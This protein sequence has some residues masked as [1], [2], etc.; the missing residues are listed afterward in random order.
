MKLSRRVTL[1]AGLGLI[2]LIIIAQLSLNIFLKQ[3]SIADSLH[4]WA[5]ITL[6]KSHQFEG[7]YTFS[8]FPYPVVKII[9]PV[10]RSTNESIELFKAERITLRLNLFLWRNNLPG[11]SQ[12]ELVSPR[13]NFRTNKQGKSNWSGLVDMISTSHYVAYRPSESE[14]QVWGLLALLAVDSEITG[15]SIGWRDERF[16]QKV[17]FSDWMFSR[18]SG[19]SE[20][21][22]SLDSSASMQIANTPGMPVSLSGEAVMLTDG[23]NILEFKIGIDESVL[24]GA[25]QA[26][27]MNAVPSYALKANSDRI[28]LSPSLGWLF[29]KYQTHGDLTLNAN[30]ISSGVDLAGVLSSVSGSVRVEA[31]PITLYG[32]DINQ[33]L[34]PNSSNVIQDN[35]LQTLFDNVLVDL[36]V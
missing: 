2:I 1:K 4:Q 16:G 14:A 19:K 18:R 20:T 30:L 33:L 3:L 23:F 7:E 17:D 21:R 24:T 13:F 22:L 11:I 10:I 27:N 31:S 29:G 26:L 35:P 6:D 34:V 25:F 28:R 8:L 5:G 9:S 36:S 32:I 12:L 15:G